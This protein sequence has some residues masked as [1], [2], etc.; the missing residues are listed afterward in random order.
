MRPSVVL[1]MN[2]SVMGELA[3][4]YRG[5]MIDCCVWR[6]C[7]NRRMLMVANDHESCGIGY[8]ESPWEQRRSVR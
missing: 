1:E 5:D 8:K 3:N 7:G 2:R 4:R 6:A